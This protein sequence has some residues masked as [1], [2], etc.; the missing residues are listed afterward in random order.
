MRRTLFFLYGLDR[1]IGHVRA[2]LGEYNK[3]ASNPMRQLYEV[4]RDTAFNDHTYKHTTMGYLR[5]IE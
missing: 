2:V 4:L 3:N 1:N 5:D